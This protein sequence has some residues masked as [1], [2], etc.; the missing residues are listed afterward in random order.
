V[1]SE[2]VSG[3]TRQ[4]SRDFILQPYTTMKT[5]LKT[6]GLAATL[7]FALL[8]S[9][10]RAQDDN[11]V[12]FQTFYDQLASQGTWIQTDNYG[13]VWQPTENDPNWRPYTYGH[14]VDTDAGLT[15]DSN[16]PFGWATYHYGRWV[17]I[18]GT[19]WAWVPGYTWAPA[20]VSWRD[21][22][23]EV[24]WAPLP[25]DSDV[26]IDY[27]DADDSDWADG[28][29]IGDD[30]DVAYDI[31]PGCYNFCPIAFIGDSDCWRHFRNHD[32]NFAFIRHTRNVTNLNFHRD[33][34]GRFGHVRAEGPSVAALNARSHTPL[35]H[36]QLTS[37]SSLNNAGLH[38]NTLAVFAPRVD[39]A[40]FKTSRPAS[41]GQTLTK[42]NVNRGVDINR[43]LAVNSTVKPAGPTTEQIRGA[44][45]SSPS[46]ARIATV[47]THPSRPLT[48]PLNS[49]P[50]ATR[51][52]STL[53]NMVKPNAEPDRVSAPSVPEE[54]RYTGGSDAWHP[55][56]PAGAESRFTGEGA[57]FPAPVR[58]FHS[59][60][61][62]GDYH[63]NAFHRSAPSYHPQS[64]GFR[65]FAPAS[66]PHFNGGGEHFGGGA[67]AAHFS[68]GGFSGGG[69]SS[70]GGGGGAHAS[71]GGGGGHSGGGGGHH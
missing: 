28:Y 7:V 58:S 66:Q 48:Q 42:A 12:S 22:D 18:D 50:T 49:L 26:G 62:G 47:D 33:G 43:P 14:W 67:P 23:D 61:S 63:S 57:G 39:P 35:E 51:S 21:G 37:A 54:S 1:E 31:G 59:Y 69:R 25:P 5:F 41:I 30:C 29:H 3:R 64:G 8:I 52:P 2:T 38:G 70:G 6:L 10:M 9:P 65:S 4:I 68:G 24:G 53:N 20:W 34:A 46:N 45:G 11:P 56:M 44:Q 36:A 27:D 55:V 16:E 15:W 60:S 17:N 13:Y 19:G 71:S 40:T 32:D